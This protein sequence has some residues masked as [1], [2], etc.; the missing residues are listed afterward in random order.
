MN[1]A[2][3]A[4]SEI[5]NLLIVMV[6]DAY[7]Q[8]SAFVAITVLV[9]SYIQHRSGGWL[10][11]AIETRTAWQPF[12]G[13]LMGLVPGCGGAIVIMPLYI[14]NVV[15]FGTVVATLIATAGDSAF[16][17]LTQAPMAAVVSYGITFVVAVVWGMAIERYGFGVERIDQAV[18]TIFDAGDEQEAS[19]EPDHHVEGVLSN[20]SH[21][22]DAKDTIISST[23]WILHQVSKVVFW[24]W[25]V[26]AFAGVILGS[27]FLAIG[28]PEVPLVADL[29]FNGLFTIVGLTG[30]LLSIFLYTVGRSYLGRGDFGHADDTGSSY[31]AFLHAAMET[32][33]VTVWVVAAYLIYEYAVLFTGADIAG[34]V[35]SAG[36]WAPVAGALVGVIPGCGPQ[37]VLAS[38][39]AEGAIP[40]SALTANAISQDGDAL[41]PLIAIDKTAAITATV[42]TT[43]PA[44]VVGVLLHL[45]LGSMMGFGVIG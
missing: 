31:Q 18:E 9:F 45:T 7:L 34:L 19:G 17:I 11:D 36:L 14:R 37:I 27:Y 41:F 35:A 16:V 13:S 43:V 42:Y 39:Y 6:R 2:G 20:K 25:W 8:V 3:V 21:M 29:S 33:F 22:Y 26:A 38:A 44:L 28:A 15:G 1:V 10:V 23:P 32:S 24:I 12:I 40:F 30:T 4:V 5:V